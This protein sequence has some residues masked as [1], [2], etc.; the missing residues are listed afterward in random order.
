MHL[1]LIGAY[2][3][4][5]GYHI[6]RPIRHTTNE[7][8]RDVTF[9]SLVSEVVSSHFPRFF[10]HLAR[11]APAEDHHR[12]VAYLWGG[13]RCDAP[14]FG[15]TMRIFLQATLYEKVRFLPFSSKNCKIQQCLMVFCVIKFQKNGRI[16]GFH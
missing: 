15:R 9:C 6:Y 7:T 2:G 16:C 12:T 13:P 4:F 1:I 10:G 14:P 8:V 3:K 11:T 5:Y